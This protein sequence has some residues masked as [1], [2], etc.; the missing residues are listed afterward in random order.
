[1]RQ[2]FLKL[3]KQRVIMCQTNYV[4]SRQMSTIYDPVKDGTQKNETYSREKC[5]GIKFY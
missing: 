5:L 1:M 4:V 3:Y 2:G